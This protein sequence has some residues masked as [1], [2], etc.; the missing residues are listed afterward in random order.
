MTEIYLFDWFNIQASLSAV[1][2]LK[3]KFDKITAKKLCL[4]ML[5]YWENVCVFFL[6]KYF[7]LDHF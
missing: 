2:I 4:T 7:A 6:K 5:S 1:Y 3:G